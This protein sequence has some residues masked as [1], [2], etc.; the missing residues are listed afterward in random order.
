MALVIGFSFFYNTIIICAVGTGFPYS[1]QK[2][3]IEQVEL[4][5]QKTVLPVRYGA[6]FASSKNTY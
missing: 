2:V 1:H 5:S 6:V 3:V 4:T